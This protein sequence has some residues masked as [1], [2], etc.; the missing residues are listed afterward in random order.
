MNIKNVLILIALIL[1]S[2]VY[3]QETE[4]TMY[5]TVSF[6][7]SKNVYVK[8]DDTEKI[9]VGDTLL[10]RG[11]NDPCLLVSDKSSSSAVCSILDNCSVKIGEQIVFSFSTTA[12]K[13]VISENIEKEVIEEKRKTVVSEE[14]QK[15]NDF[16]TERIKGRIS[17]SSYNNF[18]D[19][20]DDRHRINSR[21]SLDA[22]HIG[23][24]KFSISTYLNYRHILN[25]KE[26]RTGRKNSI[27][28]VYDLS[29]RYDANPDLSITVGRKINSKASSLGA[30]D[31]LQVE[32]YFNKFFVGGIVGFRPDFI[33]FNF[34]PDLFEYGGFAGIE[35]DT[36]NFYSRTTLG[37]MEQTNGGAVDRRYVYFQHSSTIAKKLNLFSSFELDIYGNS[38]STTRLTNLYMSARYRFSRKFD[39]TVSYDSRKRII[40][41][42]TFKTE[43][44]QILDDDIARQ[45]IRAR[46]NFKPI[47]YII[48]GGSYS[49]RF[50][51]DDQ[52]KSNNIYG[53]A[54]LT[55]IP[56]VGGRFSVKYN[57]NSSN[58]LESQIISFRHSRDMFNRKLSADFYYRL[59]DYS[60]KSRDSKFKQS[61]YGTSLSYNI[62]R[63]WVF[64]ISGELSHFNNQNNY[65]FYT[66]LIKRFYSKKKKKR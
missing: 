27:F 22:N 52:N 14:E 32:K 45:G 9:K 20:R 16:Y 65:R 21:F 44:E 6:V 46:V 28:R 62:T 31:G 7:T 19:T 1:T 37:F 54:T 59:A 11:K 10:I 40:Y 3:A 41:Y 43:I 35:S 12:I 30:I 38:G 39:L 25:A 53:Y 58:Y 56:A 49:S 17:A 61:Y 57:V 18:S 42:E 8:F 36:Q 64:N 50:Q 33:D 23:D 48:I 24:S 2:V 60:Y 15:R 51:S 66:K 13:E 55:K 47:K 4:Q 34:N 26:S 63:T 5:G 29:V